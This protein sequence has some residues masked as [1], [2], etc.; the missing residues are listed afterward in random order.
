[1]L[2]INLDGPFIC[3][4]AIVPAMLEQ[5]YGRIVNIASIAGKEGNPNAAHYSASK[6]GLIALTK[7]LGKELAQHDIARQRGDARR[8]QDRDL[9]PDD[10]SSTST[11]CCR[12]FRRTRSSWSKNS[13][14][15]WR[16]WRRRIAPSP[17]ARC[18]I[19]PA[20]ARRIEMAL[21]RPGEGGCLCGAGAG[22]GPRGEPINVRD[23]PL[24]Q[25]PEGDGLALLR[26]RAVRA[27]RA[28]GSRAKPPAI[29]SSE[30]ARDGCSARQCGTPAVRLAQE[31]HRGG[32]RARPPSTT[33]TPLRRPSISGFRRRWTGS[34]STTACRNIRKAL[35]SRAAAL[36]LITTSFGTMV[37]SAGIDPEPCP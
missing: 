10:A 4:K 11:S 27:E 22:S 15:W 35:P 25:L 33:A 17:P 34:S 36:A 28:D 30:H 23:L 20:A 3:C 8:R 14:R 18:S 5:K 1:M 21:W 24:P 19:F 7:S 31:R 32:R 9:R 13:P 37:A 26:S 16:G 2:R 29:A 6:A 12:R